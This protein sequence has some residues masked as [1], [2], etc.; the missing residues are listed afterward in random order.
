MFQTEVVEAHKRII[1]I[2]NDALVV[3]ETVNAHDTEEEK[4]TMN[5]LHD[6]FSDCDAQPN[7]F[8]S[9]RDRI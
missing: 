2:S 8:D 6:L 1:P 4:N 9:Y 7:I 5:H 3:E